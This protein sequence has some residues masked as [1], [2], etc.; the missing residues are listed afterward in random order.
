M[1][2]KRNKISPSGLF[3]MLYISRLVVSLTNIQSVTL[4]TVSTDILIS[5]LLSLGITLLLSLPAVYCYK[6]HKSPFDVKWLGPLYFLFFIFMAGVNISRFS[7]FASTTLNPETQAWV[8]AFF[9]ALCA[10]Y[11]AMLGVESLSRFSFFAFVLMVTALFIMMISNVKGYEEINL[12]P[13]VNN[14]KELIFRNALFLTSNNIEIAVFLCLA[15]RINGGPVRSFVSSVTAS[16][17]TIFVLLLFM[18]AILGDSA[19]LQSF[20]IYVLFQLSKITG[21][22]RLDILHMSF[23]IMAIFL[24]TVLLIYCSSLSVKKIKNKY[25][26]MA[27][28]AGTFLISLLLIESGASSNIKPVMIILPFAVF[29]VI[30]P[31]LTLIFKKKN[32]GDELV[33]KL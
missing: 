33:K 16:N 25:K 3:F 21:L 26:C 10:C 27:G 30:I 23:W 14:S 32:G 17:T 2:Y 11:C 22:E 7:Y 15:D 12:Y 13:V 18:T 4:G 1:I 24:K 31:L 20:P 9:I 19:S 8:F 5:V 28:A 29:C 6:T